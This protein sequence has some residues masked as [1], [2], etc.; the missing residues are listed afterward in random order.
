M[1]VPFVQMGRLSPGGWSQL[2]Q[3]AQPASAGTQTPVQGVWLQS[4]CPRERERERGSQG[5]T[6]GTHLARSWD[7]LGGAGG[8]DAVMPGGKGKLEG[9]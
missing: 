3:V 9:L 2:L 8:A 1:I 6:R 5:E 7:T 4:L